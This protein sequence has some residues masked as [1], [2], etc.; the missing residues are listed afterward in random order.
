MPLDRW[1]FGLGLLFVVLSTITLVI[2]IPNDIEGGLIETFRTQKSIGDALGPTVVAVC[3]LIASLL[4]AVT[5]FFSRAKI[6]S[7]RPTPDLQSL[8]FEM[9]VAAV[10][11]VPLVVMAYSGPLTVDAMNAM[12]YEIGSYR[13]LRD[14]LPYKYIGF[15]VG[16]FMMIFGLIGVIENRLSTSASIVALA[17]VIVLIALYDVPFDNLLLPPNGDQ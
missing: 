10:L 1:T 17:A 14:T 3:A 9:R 4:M 15:L 16:G 6:P 5:S 12:G 8:S 2:W 11:I 7:D 13:E